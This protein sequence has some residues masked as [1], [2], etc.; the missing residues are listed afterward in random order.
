MKLGARAS[1]PEFIVVLANVMKRVER[2]KGHLQ[3]RRVGADP[4]RRRLGAA[5][6]RTGAR[7]SG[8]TSRGL[9][10]RHQTGRSGMESRH[11]VAGSEPTIPTGKALTAQRTSY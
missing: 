8:I 5:A 1:P 3:I 4:V 6:A 2:R 10:A 9:G 7:G 11:M